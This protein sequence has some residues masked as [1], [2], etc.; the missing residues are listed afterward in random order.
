MLLCGWSHLN[1]LIHTV[2]S[3]CTNPDTLSNS[4]ELAP[5]KEKHKCLW[6]GYGNCGP[7]HPKC[8][9]YIPDSS[10]ST[11]NNESSLQSE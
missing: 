7:V 1:Q 2:L 6:N 8:F 4:V 5:Q 11:G 10:M 9:F 3:I